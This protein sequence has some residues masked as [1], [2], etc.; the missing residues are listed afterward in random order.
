M[1]QSI[2]LFLAPEVHAASWL[3]TLLANYFQIAA[4]HK[5]V[6]LMGLCGQDGAILEVDIRN[7]FQKDRLPGPGGGCHGGRCQVS[8]GK[9]RR[10]DLNTSGN[11]GGRMKCL[12]K[13][14]VCRS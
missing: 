7:G 5:A 12:E 11:K 1:F 14:D 8:P 4:Q 3:S 13:I 10:Q 2:Q 6:S 9:K